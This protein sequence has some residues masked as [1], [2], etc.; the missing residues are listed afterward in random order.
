MP[1]LISMRKAGKSACSRYTSRSVGVV[2]CG[3]P[4]TQAM[5]NG[6]ASVHDEAVT[7]ACA[8]TRT[9]WAMSS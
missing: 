1:P 5:E 3:F 8:T 7:A 2:P 9:K 6:L 4:R